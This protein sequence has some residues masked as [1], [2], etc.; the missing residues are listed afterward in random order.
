LSFFSIFNQEFQVRGA[1]FMGIPILLVILRF[2]INR[3]PCGM[4]LAFYA[5]Y[6]RIDE[7]NVGYKAFLVF[8]RIG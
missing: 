6:L 7:L 2:A 4:I 5:L 3:I 8:I 1:E